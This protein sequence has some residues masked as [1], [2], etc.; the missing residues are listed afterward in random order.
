L[1]N[2]AVWVRFDPHRFRFDCR[3]FRFDRHRVRWQWLKH[4]QSRTAL[5]KIFILSRFGLLSIRANSLCEKVLK[6]LQK[7]IQIEALSQGIGQPVWRSF[8]SIKDYSRYSLWD[9]SWIVHSISLRSFFC[10]R[11]GLGELGRTSRIIGGTASGPSHLRKI[12]G[13]GCGQDRGRR[14]SHAFRDRF[15]GQP[16]AG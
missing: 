3:R 4:G 8:L 7:R 1:V 2:I 12:R 15:R 6:T 14:S 13:Q 16:G 11:V 5:V 9:R 10:A